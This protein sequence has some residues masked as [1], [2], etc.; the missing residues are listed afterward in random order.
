[1]QDVNA[2]HDLTRSTELPRSPYWLPM[3][4]VGAGSAAVPHR[5]H[6]PRLLEPC[7][8]RTPQLA[9]VIKKLV[10]L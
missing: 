1:M 9:A 3:P 8:N 7:G 6:G 5:H 4:S 2:R 10:F